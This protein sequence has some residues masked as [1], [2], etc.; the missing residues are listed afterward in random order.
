MLSLSGWVC[1]NEP[2]SEALLVSRVAQTSGT[3]GP[4]TGTGVDL[5]RYCPVQ[6][7]LTR[8]N[9]AKIVVKFAK[10]SLNFGQV[11]FC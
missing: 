10:N 7:Y 6:Y 3:S 2:A 4:A 8:S 9:F 1:A 11:N 5:Y